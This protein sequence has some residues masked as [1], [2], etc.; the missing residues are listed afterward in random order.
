MPST[1]QTDTRASAPAAHGTMP[2]TTQAHTHTHMRFSKV[3]CV[4]RRL[5]VATVATVVVVATVVAVVV[6]VVIVA[7]AV[8]VVVVTEFLGVGISS[9]R[10][11]CD[12]VVDQR[13]RA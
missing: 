11:D 6:V 4:W 3:V 1:V 5:N 10:R 13:A 7:F 12:F 8:A 9:R 2:S